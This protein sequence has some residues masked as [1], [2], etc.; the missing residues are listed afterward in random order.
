[1]TT[2]ISDWIADAHRGD[3]KRSVA[4]ADEKITAFLNFKISASGLRETGLTKHTRFSDK[5]LRI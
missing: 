2:D 3:G 4:R 5:M 1:M